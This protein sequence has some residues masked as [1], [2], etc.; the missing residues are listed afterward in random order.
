MVAVFLL[1]LLALVCVACGSRTSIEEPGK[2]SP[3]YRP[4]ASPVVPSTPGRTASPSDGD[5]ASRDIMAA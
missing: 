5:P 4:R 1:T 2:T 3:N